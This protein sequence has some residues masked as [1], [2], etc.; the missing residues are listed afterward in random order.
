MKTRKVLLP[1]DVPDS[2]YCWNQ[3]QNIRC[4]YFL[5]YKCVLGF[6]MEY[7]KDNICCLKDQA[8]RNLLWLENIR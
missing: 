6:E 1:I 4:K 2:N 5:Y 7:D 3:K 8:C